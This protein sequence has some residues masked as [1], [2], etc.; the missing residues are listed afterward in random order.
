MKINSFII[1]VTLCVQY[2]CGYSTAGETKAQRNK[3]T[4]PREQASEEGLPPSPF[5]ELSLPPLPL[6]LIW[7]K[8]VCL[9]HLDETKQSAMI[10]CW[11]A[12][13]IQIEL[14]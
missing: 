1:T 2:H 14:S 6:S 7:G 11:C 9:C 5:I 12:P 10:W 13:K 3:V 4:C 8:S